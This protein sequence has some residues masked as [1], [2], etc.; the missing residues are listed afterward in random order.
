MNVI[1][2]VKMKLIQSIK[3]NVIQSVKMKVILSVKMKVILSVKMKVILSIKMK[4]IQSIKM[5]V[6]LSS[7]DA[8]TQSGI[9][10]NKTGISLINLTSPMPLR[11]PSASVCAAYVDMRTSE[12]R[13]AIVELLP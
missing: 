3:M 5:K 6:I 7:S 11:A 12:K 9:S 1:Q 2:S 8:I 13:R 10:G 4:L